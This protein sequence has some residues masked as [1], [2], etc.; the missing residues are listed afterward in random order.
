M[1]SSWASG[2]EAGV[3]RRRGVV[4]H[5]REQVVREGVDGRV[6]GGV[7]H[8]GPRR[9]AEHDTPQPTAIGVDGLPVSEQP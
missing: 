8:A 9:G 1:M 5:R 2:E 3:Q 6:E 7:G 4:A